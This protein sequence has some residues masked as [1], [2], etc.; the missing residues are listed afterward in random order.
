M[1][2]LILLVNSMHTGGA[3]RVAA[4]LVNAWAARG[5][6]VTLLVTFS[7]RGGCHYRIH[8]RVAVIYL[9][10]LSGVIG[11]NLCGYLRRFIALRRFIKRQS[12]NAVVSFLTDVNVV[13]LLA[14]RGLKIPVIVSERT[15]PPM[16]PLGR[17]WEGLRRL[18]YPWADRVVMLSQD[19]VD[20]LKAIIPVARGVII[21]NPVIYPLPIS[22]PLLEVCS[23]VISDRKV[24]LAVG[25]MDS[26]KQ[27]DRLIEAFFGLSHRF[28]DWDLVILGEGPERPILEQQV[29]MLG[30]QGRV[31][32]PGRAGNIGQWYERADLYVMSSRFEGFPNVLAEAMAHGCAAVSYDCDTGPRDIIRH[33]IDGLLVKPVGDVPALQAA[34]LELMGDDL[35]RT[36][37]ANNAREVLDRFSSTKILE[38]WDSLLCAV[39]QEANRK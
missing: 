21:P 12:A 35:K 10:D 3:E 29:T 31:M 1:A 32:L 9:S 14:T 37:M 2:R 36:E 19:G 28:Q 24:M 13:T 38:I 34:L 7:G 33:G 22:E 5:D 20:W 25:R 11:R 16:M 18:T 27:F 26:G 39:A 8:D 17:F 4:T 6:E 23:M 30:L 15:H